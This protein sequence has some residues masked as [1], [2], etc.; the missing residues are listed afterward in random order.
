MRSKNTPNNVICERCGKH[1]R[2]K[3]SKVDTARF[4]S[5][6]CKNPPFVLA[7]ESCG[8]DFSTPPSRKGRRRY[9]SVECR[10]SGRANNPTDRF[11]EL[12]PHRPDGE[13]WE[14]TGAGDTDGY[15]VFKVRG[16]I[17]KMHRLSYELHKGPIP[18]GMFVCHHCDNPRC[19]NPN[20]LFIGTPA[21]NVADRDRKGR[22]SRKHQ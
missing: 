2:V 22:T 21:D 13:C 16:K 10:L 6:E 15:G 4:C 8:K 20:H 3:P 14:H 5:K 12:L 7:C 18:D 11:F 17:V 9:C 19:C 1:F